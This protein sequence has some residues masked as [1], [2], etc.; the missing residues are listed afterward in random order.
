MKRSTKF[1][2]K[3]GAKVAA[4]GLMVANATGL[5]VFGGPAG[6]LVGTPLA[7]GGG[8]A[9]SKGMQDLGQAKRARVSRVGRA[10]SR[11]A[12]R[13]RSAAGVSGARRMARGRSGGGRGGVRVGGG[14]RS[15]YARDGRGRF[16]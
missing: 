3:G 9:F 2:V 5:A 8:Y 11:A 4:G 12:G 15:S 13:N 7:Y 10:T 16:R 1:S 14:R 6:A